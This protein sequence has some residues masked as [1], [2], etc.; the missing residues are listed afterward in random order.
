MTKESA[1]G[2]YEDVITADSLATNE[3]YELTVVYTDGNGADLTILKVS[4]KTI[5]APLD[6]VT[7][8]NVTSDNEATINEVI[9]ELNE[10]TP[11]NEEEQKQLNEAL[12]KCNSLFAKVE[13]AR[14]ALGEAE[15]EA[16]VLDK[17]RATIFW[18]NDVEEFLDKINSLLENPNMSPAETEKLEDYKS[19]AEEILEIIHTPKEY[20]SLRFFYLIRDYIVWTFNGIGWLFSNL[21]NIS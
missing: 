6:G 3:N 21:F 18:E 14:K 5:M 13:E 7:E 19:Q 10:F 12:D 15:E 9:A 2:E 20:I 1:I 11:E 4:V 17:E 16:V 8:D